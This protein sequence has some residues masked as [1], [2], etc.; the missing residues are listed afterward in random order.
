M[1][2]IKIFFI[3]S[4]IG[5]MLSGFLG[6]ILG[7][8]FGLLI[9]ALIAIISDIWEMESS[10]IQYLEGSNE[11]YFWHN[12]VRTLIENKDDF[13]FEPVKKP[14]ILSLFKRSFS[15]VFFKFFRPVIFFIGNTIRILY[16]LI[17][18]IFQ[19]SL[20]FLDFFSDEN[21][22]EDLYNSFHSLEIRTNPASG[23][24]MREN[25]SFDIAGNLY[26]S[27]SLIDI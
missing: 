25:S 12:G 21:S 5:Y 23:L 22:Y 3:T 20:E 19:I 14:K 8:I 26:G 4:V 15:I 24:S 27:N 6:A 1:I 16:N 11:Y 13:V 17:S 18:N 7:G 10:F 2:Q 9:I